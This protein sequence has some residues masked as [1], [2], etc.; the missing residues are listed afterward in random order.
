MSY[1][2]V[3][4]AIH[5]KFPQAVIREGQ[6]FGINKDREIVLIQSEFFNTMRFLQNNSDLPFNLL[7]DILAIDRTPK[8]PRFDLVYILLST[9]DYSPLLVRL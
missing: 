2:N 5:K 1:K 8:T 3:S 4:Q 6:S 7:I 9:K